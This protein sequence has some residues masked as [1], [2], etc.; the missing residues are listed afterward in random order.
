MATSQELL[1]NVFKKA[2]FKINIKGAEMAL[3]KSNDGNILDD[4]AD[5]IT[6][7]VVTRPVAA[8][9]HFVEDNSMDDFLIDFMNAPVRLVD[10]E[11]ENERVLNTRKASTL[12]LADC[13]E[14]LYIADKIIFLE[15]SQ[16]T[17]ALDDLR[18]YID[19]VNEQVLWAP[20]YVAP[21][22]E[23]MEKLE[24]LASTIST[25]ANYY[26]TQGNGN[27]N[28]NWLELL[29]GSVKNSSVVVSK[30]TNVLNNHF[31]SLVSGTR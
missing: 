19:D 14:L 15:P 7:K 21:P 29:G 18:A 27:G 26:R 13:A 28:L 4:S 23:D 10:D 1:D 16:L 3:I 25:A 30:N 6:P 5:I 11:E 22:K 9:G 24:Q 17:L 12:S 20:H 8:G 31:N 2:I